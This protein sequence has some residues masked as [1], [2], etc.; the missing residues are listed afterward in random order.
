MDTAVRKRHGVHYTPARLADFL[1]EQTVR[2]FEVREKQAIRILDPAC[3]D[4]ELLLA[5]IEA[6]PALSNRF[7]RQDSIKTD[8]LPSKLAVVLMGWDS[9]LAISRTAISSKRSPK[10]SCLIRL[11]SSLRIHRTCA[12]RFWADRRLKNWLGSLD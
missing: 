4:G 12:R 8:E 1:A 11:T 5:L 9:T 3:G 10:V 6:L 2:Q 7:L